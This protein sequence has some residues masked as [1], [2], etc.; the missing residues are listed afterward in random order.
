MRFFDFFNKRT[1]NKSET[2]KQLTA[3]NSEAESKDKVSNDSNKKIEELTE[4]NTML[5]SVKDAN[6]FQAFDRKFVFIPCNNKFINAAKELFKFKSDDNGLLVYGYIDKSGEAVFRVL[7]LGNIRNNKLNIT[8]TAPLPKMTVRRIEINDFKF[9]SLDYCEFDTSIYGDIVRE[10]S[11]KHYNM[12]SIEATRKMRFI[13]SLRSKWYPDNIIVFVECEDKIIDKFSMRCVSILN[14]SEIVGIVSTKPAREYVRIS[15]PVNVKMTNLNKTSPACIYSVSKADFESAKQNGGMGL[16]VFYSGYYRWQEADANI[17]VNVPIGKNVFGEICCFN[18]N[19]KGGANVLITGCM[20]SGKTEALYTWILSMAM[21]YSPKDVSFVLLGELSGELNKLPHMANVIH[22]V[23]AKERVL[24]RVT[25]QLRSEIYKRQIVIH[26]HGCH[27][28]M[29]YNKMCKNNPKLEKLPYLYVVLDDTDSIMHL[30]SSENFL[31]LLRVR[32]WALGIQFIC[33]ASSESLLSENILLHFDS[34]W[35]MGSCN[36]FGVELKSPGSAIINGENVQLFYTGVLSAFSNPIHYN[37]K[38]RSATMQAIWSYA[39]SNNYSKNKP[40]ITDFLPEKVDFEDVI[41]KWEKYDSWFAVPFGIAD[42]VEERKFPVAFADFSNYFSNNG[43]MAIFGDASSGKTTL[44]QT[45]ITSIC[46]L[47]S[48]EEA[49]VFVLDFDTG[50]MKVFQKLPNVIEVAYDF[51]E[52]KIK[53]IIRRLEKV[54]NTRKKL[55]DNVGVDNLIV[56]KYSGGWELPHIVLAIDNFAPLF[57]LCPETEKDILDIARYGAACGIYLILTAST[58]S[59][60]TYKIKM[61]A[62]KNSIVL[63]M[64]D[65]TEYLGIVGKTEGLEPDAVAGR[66]LIKLGKKV[67][68]FQSAYIKPEDKE[69]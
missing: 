2:E 69:K 10:I 18:A 37:K 61:F 59:E 41:S 60:L 20:G 36:Y 50:A 12:P 68:E 13:D 25:K 51:E 43:H 31:A 8:A 53:G 24:E 52:E 63:H 34:K 23:Q 22:W 11:D 4:L 40:I 5:K 38:Q 66:G 48:E 47:Y 17:S 29:D 19:R 35:N 54:L 26:K 28:I 32:I 9:L 14:K 3:K 16:P 56:Y 55:F 64:A 65:R 1:E 39:S 62:E 67:L 33:T 58:P 21:C 30:K 57:S 7:A 46:E 49:S 27:S 15:D 45:I 6:F 42:D 44:L